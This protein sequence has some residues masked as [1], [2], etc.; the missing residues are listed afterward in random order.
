MKAKT[1][2]KIGSDLYTIKTIYN[3][4]KNDIEMQILNFKTIW[5]KGTDEEILNELIFCLLTPQSNARTCW[6]ALR[7]LIEKDLVL[8]GCSD[9]IKKAISIV[10]FKNKKSEYIIEARNIFTH[11]GNIVIKDK[12]N[13]ISTVQKKREWLVKTIKGFGYKEASHF[14][15]NIGFG[16]KIAILDRH[17]LKNL[18]QLGVIHSIPRSLSN[19]RY[20][21]IEAKMLELAEKIGI[22]LHHL[23]LVLWYKQTGYIFK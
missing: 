13:G 16:D 5:E 22:P 2:L 17:I 7:I 1:A 10:R 6:S 8:R 23:D 4:I 11:N 12:L 9:D 21:D 18:I 14:L 19:T 20:I 15:R 3:A